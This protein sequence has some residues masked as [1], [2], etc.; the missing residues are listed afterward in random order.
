[1]HAAAPS[2][3]DLFEGLRTIGRTLGHRVTF[4]RDGR[5]SFPLESGILRVIPDSAGRLR[6]EGWHSGR[7]SATV[8]CRA[9]D[10]DRLEAVA[11]A[12]GERVGALA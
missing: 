6:I 3:E 12:F 7:L 5:Y 8:W 2:T 4:E 11:R 1:M 9:T 10:H